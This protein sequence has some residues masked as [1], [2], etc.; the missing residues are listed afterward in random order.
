MSKAFYFSI[1]CVIAFAIPFSTYADESK[2][3]KTHTLTVQEKLNLL[4]TIEITSKKEIVAELD[5]EV[6]EQVEDILE[7]LAQLES[8][9]ESS[10]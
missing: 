8:E 9:T 7:E 5:R 4:E 1:V 6:D 2:I 10:E 3:V